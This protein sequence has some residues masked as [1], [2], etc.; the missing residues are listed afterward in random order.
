MCRLFRYFC[1]RD[2]WDAQTF[3]KGS[4]AGGILRFLES[5]PKQKDVSYVE[6]TNMSISRLYPG[7]ATTGRCR[8]EKKERGGYHQKQ[9][10]DRYGRLVETETKILIWNPRKFVNHWF[11]EAFTVEKDG[12]GSRKRREAALRFSW[13]ASNGWTLLLARKTFTSVDKTWFWI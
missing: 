10:A 6:G 8:V 5:R 3:S 9:H 13:T 2:C 4:K 1:G 12:P 7:V 11:W